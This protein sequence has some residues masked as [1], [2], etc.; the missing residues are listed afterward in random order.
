M[1][2]KN[3]K[4]ES[5]EDENKKRRDSLTHKSSGGGI[6][7]AFKNMGKSMTK[8]GLKLRAKMAGDGTPIDKSI[9]NGI[10]KLKKSKNDVSKIKEG[11]RNLYNNE[12]NRVNSFNV[13][14]KMLNELEIL[15]EYDNLNKCLKRL[16]E[17]YAIMGDIMLKHLRKMDEIFLN[18]FTNF[19]DNDIENAQNVKLKWKKYKINFDT[20]CKNV[21]KYAA[22]GMNNCS[23][24]SV[25]IYLLF[26][27]NIFFV[28]I[29]LYNHGYIYMNI[30]VLYFW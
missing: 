12:V 14:T 10:T 17:V 22:K 3:K 13:F 29:Y 15:N 20:Q 1:F 26:K 18:K 25:V 23:I 24:L 8:G 16:G 6:T 5:K 28:N 19:I 27:F 4:Q 7:K 9:E 11:I 2:R 30:Y 21:N